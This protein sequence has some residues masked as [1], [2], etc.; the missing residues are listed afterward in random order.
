[1]WPLTQGCSRVLC[2]G[3]G[4]WGGVV[5]HKMD[6][7]FLVVLAAVGEEWL[8]ERAVSRV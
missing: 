6:G 4:W 8:S 5:L 3:S 2:N 1:V 7:V